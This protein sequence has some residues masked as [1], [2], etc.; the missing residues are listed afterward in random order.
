[1]VEVVPINDVKAVAEMGGPKAPAILIGATPQ[2]SEA[3][4]AEKYR[5]YFA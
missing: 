1:M 4:T 2:I 5:W 3:V